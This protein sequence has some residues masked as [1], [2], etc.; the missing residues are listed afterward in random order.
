MDYKKQS[1]IFSS[2][3]L[4]V[5]TYSQDKKAASYKES[6]LMKMTNNEQEY[7]EIPWRVKEDVGFPSQYFALSY[8]QQNFIDYLLDKLVEMGHNIESLETEIEVDQSA[9]AAVED[10]N[11]EMVEQ[12]HQLENET[13]LLK[14]ELEKK[15][16]ND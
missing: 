8:E 1:E 15:V 4:K 5:G 9:M 16:F 14:D 3:A 13:K 12:I 6:E 2:D 7:D 10:L 11:V